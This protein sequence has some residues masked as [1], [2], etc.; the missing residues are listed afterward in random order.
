MSPET[1]SI[2][3]KLGTE[4]GVGKYSIYKIF[5][6]IAPGAPVE[7]GKYYNLNFKNFRFSKKQILRLS[8]GRFVKILGVNISKTVR[9]GKSSPGIGTSLALI[10]SSEIPKVRNRIPA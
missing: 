6:G 9:R 3:T 2:W 1:G 4:V 7:K 8:F 10:R 5:G